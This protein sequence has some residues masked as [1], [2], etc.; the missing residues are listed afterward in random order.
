MAEEDVRTSQPSS[1]SF[2]VSSQSQI[3]CSIQT[4]EG[5]GI[6]AHTHTTQMPSTQSASTLQIPTQL[7]DTTVASLP[8]ALSTISQLDRNTAQTILSQLMTVGQLPTV[9]MDSQAQQRLFNQQ[10]ASLTAPMPLPR[11]AHNMLHMPRQLRDLT[12]DPV[13][14]ISPSIPQLDRDASQVRQLMQLLAQQQSPVQPA[15]GDIMQRLLSM[16]NNQIQHEAQALASQ[17]LQHGPELTQES[18]NMLLEWIRQNA[19]GGATFSL[20]PPPPS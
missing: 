19:S 18:L 16:S 7:G 15:Q 20:P 4:L 3:P 6:R 1:Q 2:A 9:A 14:E 11:I 8:H 10:Y 13:A 5:V 12:V 17:N